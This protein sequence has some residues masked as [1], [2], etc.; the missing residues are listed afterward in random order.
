MCV[1][2]ILK[3]QWRARKKEKEKCWPLPLEGQEV[4]HETKIVSAHRRGIP[5]V[6][7]ATGGYTPSFQINEAVQLVTMEISEDISTENFSLSQHPLT[8]SSMCPVNSTSVCSLSQHTIPP[9]ALR[10]SGQEEEGEKSQDDKERRENIQ[11]MLSYSS[12]SD[13]FVELP[14]PLYTADSHG[15]QCFSTVKPPG[16]NHASENILRSVTTGEVPFLE[17]SP[18]LFQLIEREIGFSSSERLPTSP[19]ASSQQ[20]LSVVEPEQ[21]EHLKGA[22]FEGSLISR[23]QLPEKE[24]Q[25]SEE[26]QNTSRHST[27]S[28]FSD[29]PNKDSLKGCTTSDGISTSTSKSTQLS[30]RG[31]LEFSK[32]GQATFSNI[33]FHFSDKKLNEAAITDSCRKQ[34]C[35]EIAMRHQLRKSIPAEPSPTDAVFAS[36]SQSGSHLAK[37]S[38]TYSG[39]QS[40]IVEIQTGLSATNSTTLSGFSIE[41]EH[42]NTEIS[43]FDNPV[44]VNV[45]FIRRLANPIFQSTPGGALDLPKSIRTEFPRTVTVQKLSSGSPQMSRR[46]SSSKSSSRST[47]AARFEKQNLDENHKEA[48]SERDKTVATSLQNLKVQT[49]P[50]LS[51]ME[52]VG[53]WKTSQSLGSMSFDSLV[54]RGLTGVSPKQKAYTAIA[55]SLNHILSQRN[56]QAGSQKKVSTSLEGSLLQSNSIGQ[57][58]Q[59]CEPSSL[60]RSRSLTSVNEVT[61]NSKQSNVFETGNK[62]MLFQTE[63]KPVLTEEGKGN[64]VEDGP[65]NISDLVGSVDSTPKRL[66]SFLDSSKKITDPNFEDVNSDAD[67]NTIKCQ[68]VIPRLHKEDTKASELVQDQDENIVKESGG[69]CVSTNGINLS[70]FSDVSLNNELNLF[71]GSQANSLEEQMQPGSTG[72]VSEQSLTS[73]EVDNYVPCWSPTPA[74]PEPKELNIE[75]RIPVYLR[76]LGIDQSPSTILPPFV[77]RGPVRERELS[78]SEL[79]T[80]KGSVDTVKSTLHSEGLDSPVEE[81]ILQTTF[82]STVSIS[83]ALGSHRNND[84]PPGTQPFPLQDQ[85]PSQEKLSSQF[86][87]ASQPSQLEFS[88]QSPFTS[89]AAKENAA[90]SSAEQHKA[91]SASLSS[92]DSTDDLS[93]I[94]KPLLTL[95]QKCGSGELASTESPSST[96]F[97]KRDAVSRVTSIEGTALP[98]QRESSPLNLGS[99]NL[100]YNLNRNLESDSFVGTKTLNEIRKLLAEAEDSSSKRVR[101]GSLSSSIQDPEELCLFLEQNLDSF[102]D[103]TISSEEE[104]HQ[105]PLVGKS[106]SSE[107]LLSSDYF[108]GSVLTHSTSMFH[109]SSNSEWKDSDSNVHLLGTGMSEDLQ[110][111]KACPVSFGGVHVPVNIVPFRRFEPEG[112]SGAAVTQTILTRVAGGITNVPEPGSPSDQNGL[113]IG[114]Q[115]QQRPQIL[116]SVSFNSCKEDIKEKDRGRDESCSTDSLAARVASLL[117]DESPMA[118]ATLIINSADTEQ[119]RTREL[120]KLQ[121]TSEPLP[122]AVELNEED[123]RRIDEIKAELLRKPRITEDSLKV[124]SSSSETMPLPRK[125]NESCAGRLKVADSLEETQALTE[126]P[127]TSQDAAQSLPEVHQ[128]K[129]SNTPASIQATNKAV[130][131]TQ[132]NDNQLKPA[133][134]METPSIQS[135]NNI[136]QPILSLTAGAGRFISLNTAQS[137]IT[138]Q[139]QK[140]TDNVF[141]TSVQLQTPLRNDL[142]ACLRMIADTSKNEDGGVP[143]ITQMVTRESLNHIASITFSS[144]KRIP[145]SSSSFSSPINSP[146]KT[147][148]HK[149]SDKPVEEST[150]KAM[151]NFHLSSPCTSPNLNKIEDECRPVGVHL[152]EVKESSSSSSAHQEE[153]GNVEVISNGAITEVTSFVPKRSFSASESAK[154]G[155]F[156]IQNQQKHDDRLFLNEHDSGHVPFA[157]TINLQHSMKKQKIHVPF[158]AESVD[159][160]EPKSSRQKEKFNDSDSGTPKYDYAK[161]S[162]PKT[163]TPESKITHFPEQGAQF[164]TTCI[165]ESQFPSQTIEEIKQTSAT[166]VASSLLSP[167]KSVCSSL[168]ITVSP[169]CSDPST[170]ISAERPCILV[171]KGAE[172]RLETCSLQDEERSK[173][174][175]SLHPLGNVSPYLRSLAPLKSGL[176]SEQEF[177]YLIQPVPPALNDCTDNASIHER[178]TAQQNQSH[179][180]ACS[181]TVLEQNEENLRDLSSQQQFI[182]DINKI[183]FSNQTVKETD[184]SEKIYSANQAVKDASTVLPEKSLSADISVEHSYI[185]SGHVQMPAYEFSGITGVKQ[186]PAGL[187]VHTSYTDQLRLLPYKP[188]GSHDVFYTPYPENEIQISRSGT[189]VESSHP[190]SDDAIPPKFPAEVLGASDNFSF[191]TSFTRHQEGIYKKKKGSVR[192]AWQEEESAVPDSNVRGSK[193]PVSSEKRDASASLTPVQSYIKYPLQPQSKSSSPGKQEIADHENV[194]VGPDDTGQK[195]VHFRTTPHS[196][197]FKH[198]QK[199]I[200]QEGARFRDSHQYPDYMIDKWGLH[201]KELRFKSTSYPAHYTVGQEGMQSKG[202]LHLKNYTAKETGY[203]HRKRGAQHF[204]AL[205]AEADHSFC[206]T[207]SASDTSRES[208]TEELQHAK[209]LVNH[210]CE[211]A[212]SRATDGMQKQLQELPSNRS[213]Q[214]NGSLDELWKKFLQRQKKL[215]SFEV[216]RQGELSLVER[217]ERLARLLQNPVQHMLQISEQEEWRSGKEQDTWQQ[218][219]PRKR[220][221]ES[222]K[223]VR[224]DSESGHDELPFQAHTPLIQ[225]PEKELCT[226]HIK[227][228]LQHKYKSDSISDISSTVGH[229]MGTINITTDSETLTQTEAE[230]WTQT[231]TNS[232]ISTIDTARLIRAFGPHRVSVQPQISRLHRII[233]KQKERTEN[234]MSKRRRRKEEVRDEG[235]SQ[236]ARTKHKQSSKDLKLDSSD[237]MS[238]SSSSVVLAFSRGEDRTGIRR[239]NKAVQAG[240]FEIVSSATKK[241]TRDVG[242]T[243][244]SPRPDC[245]LPQ[246]TESGSILNP[247][248]QFQTEDNTFL[249]DRKTKKCIRQRPCEGIAWI[250]PVD[251]LKSESK[252]ENHLRSFGPGPAWFEPLSNTKPW[253]QPLREKHLQERPVRDVEWSHKQIVTSQEKPLSPLVRLTLQV[254]TLLFIKNVEY[255]KVTF[256]KFMVAEL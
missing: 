127:L 171:E 238:T 57:E 183:H 50:T 245:T 84:T 63:G 166:A 153:S 170:Y 186:V 131:V 148:F 145:S 122:T 22:V 180:N 125:L 52:K 27:F 168:H 248:V 201:E 165:R 14:K 242:L 100:P 111:E 198:S 118:L 15:S 107:N 35:S 80:L 236:T 225:K 207:H 66:P 158:T 28:A 124:S 247:K 157:A 19:C 193:Q 77:P 159:V 36:S 241:N 191:K 109:S 70:Q 81:D 102:H 252:K 218:E 139:L 194:R 155:S 195:G 175:S 197:D 246:H 108:K 62:E 226:D 106:A 21:E 32:Y 29:H 135:Q 228:I 61:K 178:V 205:R 96:S 188:V 141:D 112:C 1:P 55:D 99:D 56:S 68:E 204:S 117:K 83:V 86:S 182:E 146:A 176:Q 65:L 8:A 79:L 134:T 95:I 97:I 74:S 224:L 144:R 75:E 243:F 110:Q 149:W 184:I 203:T 31:K 16:E 239:L 115:Q 51:Y 220:E 45:S 177:T 37:S 211:L 254:G 244:P 4:K 72:A 251:D 234:K 43:P 53:S 91:K 156:V 48:D 40:T 38:E 133:A 98:L 87:S 212:R 3:R 76:N 163:H 88:A 11:K 39:K 227:R 255:C 240:D 199:G 230:S 126:L 138:S 92:A 33:A 103:S 42:I 6:S 64:K 128:S 167:S 12:S 223:T 85:M 58:E 34:L 67:G 143:D 173:S 130:A 142:D 23:T 150:R 46:V 164:K 94:S 26:E 140:L 59:K 256:L 13:Q 250:V 160:H 147:M 231:E 185:K 214:T 41:R 136:A 69:I 232:T 229:Q 233:D 93:F 9:S 123:R 89:T 222:L 151:S 192:V 217:L 71:T 196:T 24:M 187:D 219:H 190:G 120:V 90:I 237:T 189:S 215:N 213:V 7:G 162:S 209:P 172:E 105:T 129:E 54:L 216:S 132:R 208:G 181:G 210:H 174:V 60:N 202:T 73:L 253:R 49:L 101:F 30:D 235:H 104:G 5:D 161:V 154:G 20:N 152:S 116:E 44:P 18:H 179:R 114:L 10:L 206:D 169:K 121:L 17:N 221:R 200:F 137:H 119:H 25:A 2:S 113:P 47:L 78:P 82:H 249:Q